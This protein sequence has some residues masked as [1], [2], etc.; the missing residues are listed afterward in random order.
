MNSAAVSDPARQ[1][2]LSPQSSLCY[3]RRD[4]W[5]Q[6]DKIEKARN[7][8]RTRK[9]DLTSGNG[10]VWRAA[11]EDRERITRE[12]PARDDREPRFRRSTE[13]RQPGRTWS[14]EPCAQVRIL[15]GALS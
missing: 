3:K 2:A 5:T 1:R 13:V 14:P 12:L 4:R 15:V 7:P 9:T 8:A 11:P 10:R 6:L